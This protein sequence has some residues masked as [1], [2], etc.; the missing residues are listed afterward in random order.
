MKKLKEILQ[1][2]DTEPLEI[3]LAIL[4]AGQYCYP[5][6]AYFCWHD[7][8]PD[9]Y[10]IGGAVCSIGMLVGNLIGSISLRKWSANICLIIIL[11]ISVIS[12]YKGIDNIQIYLVFLA[13]IVAL[14]WV[15]WRC[16]RQEVLNIVHSTQDNE[17]R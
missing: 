5:S 1:Y 10:F 2:G 11:G 12:L 16:S 17:K 3:I 8:I 6:P 4:I 15:T 9:Y 13:E 14:F 7:I